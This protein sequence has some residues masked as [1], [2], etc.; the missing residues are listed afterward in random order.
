MHGT[1]MKISKSLLFSTAITMRLYAGTKGL[2]LE[3]GT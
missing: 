2:N 3:A 1:T